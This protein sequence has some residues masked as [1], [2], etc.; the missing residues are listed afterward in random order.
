MLAFL[1][2]VGLDTYVYA[3]KDDP[4]HRRRWRDPYPP[5]ALDRLGE[6]ATAAS[7]HGVR[8]WYAISPGLSLVYSD[9]TDY[10]L[11]WEK[12]TSLHGLGV[13]HFALLLDDIPPLLADRA[14]RR[15][16][17]SLAAAH[18]HLANR[19]HQDLAARGDTLAVTPTTYT[20]AWGDRTYLAALGAS[21]D[22]AVPFFWTGPD[23]ASP[24]ITAA[25]VR[26]WTAL[27]RRRPILWDNYPVNDYARWRLFLGAYRGRERTVPNHVAGIVANPMNEAH[28]SMLPLATMAAYVR[29]PAGY[30]PD[31]ALR[32]AAV[33]LYGP[34]AATAL[35]PFLAAYGDY[36]WDE[37]R[38]ESLFVP[39]DSVPAAAIGRSLAALDSALGRLRALAAEGGPPLAPLLDELEPFVRRTRAR[40]R[41]RR[42]DDA[43]RA[44]GG[45]LIYRAQ[46][47]R[48]PAP[49]A[50]RPLL[51]DGDLGEWQDGPWRELHGGGGPAPRVR[52]AWDDAHW[53]MALDV[54]DTEREVRPGVRLG[55]GDHVALIVADGVGARLAPNDRWIFVTPP[56]GGAPGTVRQY[57]LPLSGF[58]AKWLGDN[59]GMAVS[60][61]LLST[62]ARDGAGGA[63]AESSGVRAAVRDGPRGYQVELAVPRGAAAPR[64]SL[65]VHDRTRDGRAVWSLA[66]R[67]YP[68][69][70]AT[71]ATL[72]FRSDARRGDGDRPR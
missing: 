8:F 29:D 7:R 11:L 18:A 31:A 4:Y 35:Q 19:L 13:R 68:G 70:P 60:A 1:G 26:G 28:A 62:F 63:P 71:Y 43:Y 45:W 53:Y 41:Q 54:G 30:D 5:A 67:N 2:R 12:L 49:A 47:D 42:A 38:F 21:V 69:N 6:L 44:D 14:D 56:A 72:D 64:L 16:F 22:P 33:A 34:A 20:D 50:P 17:G 36:G 25:H 65:T 55:E 52:F 48:V 59:E 27:A 46:L 10:R 9:T 51:V 23:V 37:N 3:P 40:L 66:R 58:M 61:F 57:R 39:R 24:V 15:T 32:H